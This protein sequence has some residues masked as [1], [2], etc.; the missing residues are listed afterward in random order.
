MRRIIDLDAPDR[1]AAGA[2][3][4][5]DGQAFAIQATRGSRIVTVALEREQLALLADRVL[6]IIDELERRGLVAIDAGPGSTSPEAPLTDVRHEDFRA[7]T[8]TIG[9]DDDAE[10]VV[11]EAHAMVFDAG[12]GE[13]APP[14][15]ERPPPDDPPD[16]D[17][18]G[19]DI[20]RVRLTPLMAGRFA[21]RAARLVVAAQP[22]CP[23]CGHPLGQGR[24]LCPRP[25]GSVDSDPADG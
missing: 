22:T 20:L 7:G 8:L 25:E 1:F 23:T 6:A 4:P 3:G 11:V 2:M 24:H 10:R 21:E 15:G 13:S 14:P 12:A 17:P 5:A 19:P 9:W 18:L 16:D